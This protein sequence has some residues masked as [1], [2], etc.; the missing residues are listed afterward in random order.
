MEALP[1]AQ[2]PCAE[3]SLDGWGPLHSAVAGVGVCALLASPW[4]QLP[5][6]HR[7]PPPVCKHCLQ[8]HPCTVVFGGF[9]GV[10]CLYRIC[11]PRAV[12]ACVLIPNTQ[13]SHVLVTGV[14]TLES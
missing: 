7:S 12:S 13:V 14:F 6:L 1:P 2:R 9:D 8:A 10:L 3:E 11:G 5:P 4:G